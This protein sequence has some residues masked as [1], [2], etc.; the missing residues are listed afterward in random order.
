MTPNKTKALKSARQAKGI[1][2]KVISMIESGEYCPEI[3]QQAD[4]AIGLVRACK[5]ELL[6]GHLNNCLT[7][8]LKDETDP[9]VK[10][11]MKI[12]NLSN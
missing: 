10:E 6:S 2:D 7:K 4:A 11:L 12:Y 8:R 3:I 5:K 9:T 1:L